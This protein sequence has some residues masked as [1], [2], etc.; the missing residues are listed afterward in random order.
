MSREL[1]TTL[2]EYQSGLD[3][4]L[5]LA[6]GSICI[7][8]RDLQE[9]R[10]ESTP[11]LRGIGKLLA[12]SP[13]HS[14]HIAIRDSGPLSRQMPGLM[15]LLKIHS[16]NLFIVEAPEQLRSLTDSMIIADGRHALVRFHDSHPRSKLLLNDPDEVQPYAT[17]FADI[18]KEG[19][20]PISST[21]LGL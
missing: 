1:L 3:Q 14:L 5:N 4:L 13:G 7:F 6:E 8:D 10:L 19:G 2:S 9:L 16:H 18:L 17:R 11:R 20:T 12:A 21:T 15:E